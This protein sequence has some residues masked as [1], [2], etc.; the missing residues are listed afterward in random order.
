MLACLDHW[1]DNDIH[2]Y[3]FIHYYNCLLFIL[4]IYA[5]HMISQSSL[6]ML[7]I[8]HLQNPPYDQDEIQGKF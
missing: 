1:Y 2:L 4:A 5:Y 8:M 7:R 3:L 6:A